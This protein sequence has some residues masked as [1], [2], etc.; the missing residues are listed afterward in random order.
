[1]KSKIVNISELNA[2][3]ENPDQMPR[4]AASNLGLHRL[5]VSLLRDTRHKWVKAIVLF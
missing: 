1:M 5:P 3:S 2:N 4:S